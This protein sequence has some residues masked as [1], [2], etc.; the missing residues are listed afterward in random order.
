MSDIIA[1]FNLPQTVLDIV[2]QAPD[3]G[4]GLLIAETGSRLMA[5]GEDLMVTPSNCTSLVQL[6]VC[7]SDVKF[8]Y[9]ELCLLKLSCQTCLTD[10]VKR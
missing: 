7:P 5:V 10:A 3:G 4:R 1:T 6:S 9:L 8:I 2:R